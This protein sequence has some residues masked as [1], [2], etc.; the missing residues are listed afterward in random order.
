MILEECEDLCFCKNIFEGQQSSLTGMIR[1]LT[2]RTTN[3][4]NLMTSIQS[5][6]VRSLLVLTS[7]KL[8]ESFE[9]EILTNC[10]FLKVLD[11][12]DNEKDLEVGG[13][14][15]LK[16]FRSP[17][18]KIY[19]GLQNTLLK[20][21]GMLENLETLNL[22]KLHFKL[23]LPK[24]ICKLRKLRHLLG[25]EMS[26]ILMKE[27]IGGMTSLQTLS[28]VYLDKGEKDN[29]VVELIQELGK[30]KELRELVLEDVRGKHMGALSSSISEM[31]Q[32]EKLCINETTPSYEPIDLHLNSPPPKL[33]ILKLRGEFEKL[34][35]WI[36]KLQNLVMLDLKPS[37]LRYDPT[38][39]LLNDLPNL[40]SLTLDYCPSNS[41]LSFLKFQAGSFKNLKELSI[42]DLRSLER[43][44]IYKGA[45]PSLKMFS[46]D[47]MDEFLGYLPYGI[48]D[49]EKLEVINYYGRHG[50]KVSAETYKKIMNHEIPSEYEDPELWQR[51]Q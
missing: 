29:S 51:Q 8:P 1:R 36:S 34:P 5:S 28:R 17:K 26:L 13:L 47:V 18:E 50:C 43:I 11:F 41:E 10:R 38:L 27:G 37:I 23:K 22:R 14:S 46:I 12:E 2:I 7:K 9:R 30:L 6:H 40:L 4:D 35:E 49:L 19:G 15:H 16:Y 21:I 31:Q 44:Y 45:L 48:E 20:S 33:Q 24:E 32:L 3:L 42:F 25:S 39:K